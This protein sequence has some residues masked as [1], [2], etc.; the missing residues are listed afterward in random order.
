MGKNVENLMAA[1]FREGGRLGL[2]ESD[3][4]AFGGSNATVVELPIGFRLFKLTGGEAK[5]HAKYGV[6]PWWSPVYPYREDNEG[7]L[8]RFEQAKLNKIDMSSMVRYMSAVCVDWN[9]LDNY[10]EVVTRVPI[11]AFWGTFAPQKKWSD[12]NKK[13]AVVETWVSHGSAHAQPAA[14]PDDIGVLEAWQ[15]FIPRL[16]DEHIKRD[17]VLSAHDMVTLG[18]H[19]SLA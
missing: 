2:R 5:A 9:T 17:S 7:A 3:I 4:S 16:K 1:D 6:T 13:S 15:F 19:F 11:S 8:G 18:H 14:L 10:I 12:E